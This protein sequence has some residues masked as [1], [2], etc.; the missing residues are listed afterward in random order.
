MEGVY[1]KWDEEKNK[2]LKRERRVSFE[3]V[4]VALQGEG[5][6]DIISS[7]GR[8]RKNQESFVVEIGG[9]IYIVPFVE[10]EGEV[11]LKTIYL[12]RKHKKI[13]SERTNEVGPRDLH[14]E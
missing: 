14:R 1:F 11:F 12:S 13:Y 7:P 8:N 10:S 2:L 3:D 6:V 5:L 4:V 9:T